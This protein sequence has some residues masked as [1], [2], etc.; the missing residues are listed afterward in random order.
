MVEST[1]R[2]MKEPITA[3]CLREV[4]I[5]FRPFLHRK[6]NLSTRL[7]MN[8]MM[9]N[10]ENT[11]AIIRYYG[12]WAMH[13]IGLIITEPVAV[14]EPAAALTPDARSLVSGEKLRMWR[15]V[16]RVVHSCGSRIGLL[17]SHAGMLR[18][19]DDA[20][21]PS[22]INPLTL[23]RRGQSMNREQIRQVVQAFGVSAAVARQIGFDAVAI[24]GGDGYLIDQFL[25]PDTNMRDDEYGGDAVARVRFAC[26]V[27]HAV[28][29]AVGR[30]FSI[31][32]RYHF[33]GNHHLL[34]SSPAE[35]ASILLPLCDAGV[36]IFDCCGEETQEPAF[37]GSPLS[38]AA[39]TR[40][41][42]RRPVITEG[43]VGI[44]G[45]PLP[46]IVRGLQ[47][48]EFDLLAVGRAVQADAE[49]GSKVRR[50]EL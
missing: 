32:F 27:V 48:G 1:F 10:D 14:N 18:Q 30:R 25:R 46:A 9:Q 26:E 2:G 29:K 28:R 21:G 50:G 37:A 33:K 31:I 23:E 15:K 39:W 40:L 42:T 6:I 47:M 35:L 8:R 45:M 11:D 36:D 4:D 16:C 12:T 13:Q 24:Q 34:A 7:V 5:L 22:G 19:A 17:L 41:L 20:M 3:L 49:W 38:V 43:G 44:S